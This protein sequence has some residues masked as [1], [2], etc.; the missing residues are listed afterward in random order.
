MIVNILG[1]GYVGLTL[2]IFI[3]NQGDKVNI[4]DNDKSKIDQLKSGVSSVHEE[5]IQEALDF[6]IKSKNINF[7]TDNEIKSSIWVIAISYFPG[8]PE[9]FIDVI[10]NIKY[11][12]EFIPTIMIRTTIPQNK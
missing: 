3:A 11:D 12:P 7:T 6:A 10:K 2:G 8:R 4:I 1:A 9:E 5:G